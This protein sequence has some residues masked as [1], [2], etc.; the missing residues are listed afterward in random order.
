LKCSGVD[1]APVETAAKIKSNL[2]TEMKAC[3]LTRAKNAKKKN[4]LIFVNLEP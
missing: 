1:Q 2:L 4:G 3:Q